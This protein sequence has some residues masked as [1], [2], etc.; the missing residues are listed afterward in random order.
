MK[1]PNYCKS[2]RVHNK[3][4]Q[5]NKH[6]SVALQLL[7][8]TKPTSLEGKALI[9]YSSFISTNDPLLFRTSSFSLSLETIRNV[10]CSNSHQTV[11]VLPKD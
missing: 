5:D 1:I 3:Y 11:H 8:L 2:H 10:L 6:M 9:P 7:R 4:L